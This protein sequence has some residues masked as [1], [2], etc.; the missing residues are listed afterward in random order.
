MPT[1]KL[2]SIFRLWLWRASPQLFEK[3]VTPF[4]G[5]RF[6]IGMVVG[7]E[8][9]DLAPL[10]EESNP[11]LTA[12]DVTDTPAAFVADPFMIHRDGMWYMFFEI[13]DR[14]V[15]HGVIGLAKSQ[16]CRSWTYEKIVLNESFHMAYPQVFEHEGEYYM[17][18]D[19]PDQGVRLYRATRFPDEWQYEKTLLEDPQH[20]DSSII[21]HHQHWWMFSAWRENT[22]QPFAL[23][24]YHAENLQGPWLEHGRSPIVAADSR[25]ARPSGRVVPHGDGLVRFAQDCSSVY[26]ARVFAFFIDRLTCEEYAEHELCTPVLDAGVEAWNTGGMHHLDAHR[27]PA[28][29]RTSFEARP[30]VVCVDGWSS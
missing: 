3:L 29:G 11:V 5:Q 4:D 7:N 27:L 20:R 16:D 28:T 30:W 2:K 21:F 24:L 23:R 10:K 9:H 13:F 18:P 1:S 25:I 12:D 26:G 17:I 8:L 15:R 19:T 14:S 22:D 6:A